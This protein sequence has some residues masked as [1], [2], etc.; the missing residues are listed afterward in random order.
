MTVTDIITLCQ[1]EESGDLVIDIL[2]YLYEYEDMH[3]LSDENTPE[4]FI[5]HKLSNPDSILHYD[6]ET[7]KTIIGL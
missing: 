5:R 2:S 1:S 3:F 4:A 7:I 6:I